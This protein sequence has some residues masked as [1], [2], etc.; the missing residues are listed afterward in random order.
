MECM[1]SVAAEVPCCCYNISSC[2]E[3]AV[4]GSRDLKLSMYLNKCQHL[5]CRL[6]HSILLM[7]PNSALSG[8][9]TGGGL[10]RCFF[11]LLTL[12]SFPSLIWV[13]AALFVPVCQIYVVQFWN[14]AEATKG[15][16]LRDSDSYLINMILV[17]L[18]DAQV[19]AISQG[20]KVRH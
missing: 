14:I 20:W 17:I 13:N 3:N 1:Y 18:A 2:E 5:Q 7:C 11:F 6:L 12:Y 9:F 19:R 16:S 15:I 8:P 10:K 4:E